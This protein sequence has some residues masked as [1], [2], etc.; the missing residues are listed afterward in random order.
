MQDTVH[1]AITMNILVRI[2]RNYGM[3]MVDGKKREK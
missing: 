2:T 3:Y 1:T